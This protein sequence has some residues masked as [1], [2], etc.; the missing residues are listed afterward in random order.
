MYSFFYGFVGTKVVNISEIAWTENK[1]ETKITEEQIL[2]HLCQETATSKTGQHLE[3][4]QV[5]AKDYS[6]SA[7]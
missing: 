1:K 4:L 5:I 2:Q 3:V 6:L 7:L